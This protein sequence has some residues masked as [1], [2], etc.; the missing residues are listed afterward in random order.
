MKAESKVGRGQRTAHALATEAVNPRT[1]GLDRLPTLAMLRRMQG[2]DRAAVEAVGRALPQIAA[3]VEAILPRFRQGGRLIYVGAGTSGR[4]AV[5]DAAELPPTFGLPPGR[6][7]AVMAGGSRAL[8]QSVEGAEDDVA[9]ARRDLE[10]L[11]LR[12]GDSVLGIAASGRT[13]YTVAAVRYARRQG[14][15]TLALACTPRSPLA[16]A[17]K[18]AIETLTGPEAIAGST[19]LKAG[20]AQK[21]TLNLL[22]NGLMIGC[23]RVRGNRMTHLRPTN[24]KLRR[25]AEGLVMEAAGWSGAAGQARARRLLVKTG[26]D[27]PGALGLLTGAG[28]GPARP[29]PHSKGLGA[30]ARGL[31][32]P[33]GRERPLA[34]AESRWLWSTERPRGA[35]RRPARGSATRSKRREARELGI[36]S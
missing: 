11:R 2:E 14:C 19:R 15:L 21:M 7:V 27:L 34:G 30:P 35:G 13:P 4:L 9:Q 5:L 3:A 36:P 29:G 26:G 31:A 24:T 25:R 28:P 1:A 16:R 10:R 12:A 33:R 22:S 32:S 18:L 20:S 6:V 23:G 8:R 17:A